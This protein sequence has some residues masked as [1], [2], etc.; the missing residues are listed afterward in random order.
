MK[1][2][3]KLRVKKLANN[4]GSYY[5]D[6]CQNGKRNYEYLKLYI[7]LDPNASREVKKQNDEIQQVA[8]S[9]RNQR[10]NELIKS[11]WG[12]K[13]V[14]RYETFCE[15]LCTMGVPC[16]DQ[17]RACTLFKEC[18]SGDVPL[19][20]M[21]RDKILTFYKYLVDYGY[22]Q[23]T[24]K[25][26]WNRV[27]S[28]L[29]SGVLDGTIDPDC[30]RDFPVVKRAQ[31]PVTYLTAEEITKIKNVEWKHEISKRAFLFAIYTGL[32]YCDVQ[33]LKWEN[34]TKDNFIVF[35]QQKTQIDATGNAYAYTRLPLN[36]QAL[37]IIGE[38]K[39]DNEKVFPKLR[40]NAEINYDIHDASKKAGIEKHVHFHMARHTL[41]VQL[42]CNGVEIYTV[43]KLLGH[44]SV[45]TTARFYSNITEEK[46][47]DAIN[48]LPEF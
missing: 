2:I 37:E 38:R 12:V 21:S 18:F 34:I 36:R 13:K 5:L 28:T 16:Y 25:A 22:S 47:L 35:S 6:W 27:K 9:I 10:E 31:K 43:S 17:R 23:T 48:K 41:G 7:D 44:K 24:I 4:Q 46:A 26:F 32:R 8:I 39:G 33:A 19:V 30:L 1:Q 14:N 15:R 3:V 45:Q 42:L 20:E 40:H 29:K 11:P